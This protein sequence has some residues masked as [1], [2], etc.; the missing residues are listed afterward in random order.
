MRDQ[1]ELCHGGRVSCLEWLFKQ[2]WNLRA[3]ETAKDQYKDYD[4]NNAPQQCKYDKCWV[5]QS[6]VIN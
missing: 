6:I 1:C 4:R 2:L 3:T 5:T